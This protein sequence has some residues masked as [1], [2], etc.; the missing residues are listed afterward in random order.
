MCVREQLVSQGVHVC[1]FDITIA[2]LEVV[3]ASSNIN[4]SSLMSEAYRAVDDP[5]GIYGC[6]THRHGSAT[7]RSVNN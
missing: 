7:A 6:I 1:S 3:A 2:D 4:I 5:D